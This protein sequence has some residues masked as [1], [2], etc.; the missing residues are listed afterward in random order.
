MNI[1][2]AIDSALLPSLGWLLGT[3]NAAHVPALP[4]RQTWLIRHGETLV[5]DRPQGQAVIC[6]EGALWITHDPVAADGQPHQ[7]GEDTRMHVHALSDA[8]VQFVQI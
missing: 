6:T 4:V 7:P 5:V 8:T 1:A 3:P 2:A